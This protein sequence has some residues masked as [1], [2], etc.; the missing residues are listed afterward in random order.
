MH[1][2]L[3]D[4][5]WNGDRDSW[6]EPVA[7]SLWQQIASERHHCN[8]SLAAHRQCPFQRARADLLTHDVIVANHSLLMADL[9]LG[10]GAILPEPEDTL[11]VI[12]EAH[13]LPDVAREFL[14]Y[15]SHCAKVRYGLNGSISKAVNY[16]A[17]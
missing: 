2:A 14:L 1:D 4:G 15:S 17:S 10:G 16:S 13:H 6:P 9:D 12:D 3:Q 8:M 5:S 7:D 11:Y